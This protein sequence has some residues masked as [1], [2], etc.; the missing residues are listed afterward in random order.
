[1]AYQHYMKTFLLLVSGFVPFAVQALPPWAVQTGNSCSACHAHVIAEQPNVTGGGIRDGAE[2]T[3][4]MKVTV[5]PLQADLI[6]QLNGNTR[7]RLETFLVEPGQEVVLSVDVLTGNDTYA[8]QLKRLETEGQVMSLDNFMTWSNPGNPGW[9]IQGGS[10]A[11]AYFT[12]DLAEN[13]GPLVRSFT[14]M[15]EADTPPDVYDLEFA[16]AG[17]VGDTLFYQDE[18]FYLAVGMSF[19]GPFPVRAQGIV[20]T[21]PWLDYMNVVNGDWVWSYSLNGW[22]YI[23]ADSISDAGAWSYIPK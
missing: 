2:V 1:M 19:W 5:Q 17:K 14:L 12:S 3:G 8:I 15:V 23:K 13:T 18:H 7:G 21:G 11:M 10:T 4:R 9:N 16:M 20:D 6:T 22:L